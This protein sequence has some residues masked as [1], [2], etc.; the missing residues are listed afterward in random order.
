M[1]FR[2]DV[3]RELLLRRVVCALSTYCFALLSIFLAQRVVAQSPDSFESLQEQFHRSQQP[4]LK[5]YC[6]GCHSTAEHQGELDLE[7]FRSVTDIRSNVVAWQRVLEMLN[8][9]EMPPKDAP[10]QPTA[11]ELAL[12]K[13]WL[14][15]LLNADAIANAGDPGPVVLRRL[16]NAEFTYSIQ[17]L[18]GVL[19]YPAREFPT[20]SAAG[21]GFTNVGSAL[22]VSP[23][24]LQKYLDAAKQVS[25]HAVL[26][27]TGI[28]FSKSTTQCDWT[29]EKMSGIQ[30][31]YG[32]YTDSRG[33]TPVNLQG[34]QFETNGGGRLPIDEY[35]RATLA[36]REALNSA[37]KTIHQVAEEYSLNEKYLS[38][39]WN[40]LNDPDPSVVLDII[41][42]KWRTAK[43]SDINELVSTIAQWQMSLWRFT[44]IGHIG[45][46]DGPPAW[47]V[48]V[49]PFAT[50]NEIRTKLPKPIDGKNLTLFMVASDLSDGNENDFAVW[51]NPRFVSPGKPDLRLRDL[52]YASLFGKHPNGQSVDSNSLVVQAPS[53]LELLVPA[54]LVEGYEFVVTASLHLETAAE[55]TVQLQVTS[56]KPPQANSLSASGAT[57]TGAKSTWSD[58]DRPASYNAP[59]LVNE[60]SMAKKRLLNQMDAF[61]QLFPAALC[62]TK[63]VPVDEVVTLTLYHQEDDHLK[64][65]MLSHEQANQLDKLWDELHFVSQDALAQIDAYEQ[66]WQFATQDADPSAFT[67]MR[68]GIMQ[69]AETFRAR[70]L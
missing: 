38:L 12:L 19:L 33:T 51:E 46:R 36:E 63:I 13:S 54:D 44:T 59:I 17:D 47:Q 52:R 64:R 29:N 23:A 20:D 21:E 11:A 66:L 56:E 70:M 57:A 6:L 27:P 14:Q 3:L 32:K 5:K 7:A 18:T 8:E 53:V 26:V 30:S 41:R 31:F 55:G 15:S 65:L 58:G 43:P 1:F 16:N 25:S 67:P 49:Q 9:G 68:D 42:T 2:F 48:P 62:Y 24:L 69:R 45:K 34:I 37:G 60:N 4:L 28:H 40:A 22:V 39:L 10:H 61:R 35:L 50:R